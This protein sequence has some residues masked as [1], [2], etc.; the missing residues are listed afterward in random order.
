MPSLQIRIEAGSTIGSSLRKCCYCLIRRQGY[1]AQ[2][3]PTQGADGEAA[4]ENVFALGMGR[5][6]AC[7]QN[8]CNAKKNGANQGAIFFASAEQSQRH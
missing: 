1:N 2:L 8:Q 3:S 5:C 6:L 4:L 7:V